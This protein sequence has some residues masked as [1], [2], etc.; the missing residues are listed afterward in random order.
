MSIYRPT[1]LYVKQ[2]NRTGLKYFG[3]TTKPYEVM[4][5][6]L[7][8]GTYWKKHIKKHGEDITTTWCQLFEDKEQLVSYALHFSTENS[9]VKSK[10]WANL[11]PE[12]GLDGSAPGS[13]LS[14]TTKAKIR[15]A[16]A[17]QVTT[18]ETRAKFSKAR[19]GSGNNMF[20]KTHSDKLKVEMS[21]PIVV[22]GIEYIGLTAASSCLNIPRSTLSDLVKGRAKRSK[23]YNVEAHYVNP[24]DNHPRHKNL[25][26]DQ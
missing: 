7:G 3:K 23:K 2:H 16:R 17:T 4:L 13:T 5:Q 22:N 14:E 12:N 9:I 18:P 10:E 19:T 21:K 1:W 8:S 6:Y 25:D 26:G 24:A 20:G 11:K 15:T